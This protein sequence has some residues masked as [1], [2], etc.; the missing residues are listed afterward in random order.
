MDSARHVMGCHLT[1][2]MRVQNAFDDVASTIHQSL[3]SGNFEEEADRYTALIE[4]LEGGGGGDGG[5]RA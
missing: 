4:M 5:G 3:R 1:Q 2:S